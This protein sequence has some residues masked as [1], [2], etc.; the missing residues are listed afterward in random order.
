MLQLQVCA[1]LQV[2][3]RCWAAFS[4]GAANGPV[5]RALAGRFCSCGETIE[6][7]RGAVN[8]DAT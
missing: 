7:L 1:G 6:Y 5:E 2:R 4:A 3:L 8:N